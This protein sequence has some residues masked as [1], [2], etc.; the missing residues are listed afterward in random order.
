MR[1]VSRSSKEAAWKRV[2]NFYEQRTASQ[3]VLAPQT[4]GVMADAAQGR[5][6]KGAM[7]G[8]GAGIVAAIGMTALQFLFDAVNG[9][10]SS[11]AVRELSERGGRHDI[12]Q[13]KERAR[14][15]GLG[16]RD[17]T[18]RAADVLA[19]RLS[20][21]A[22]PRRHR[23]KAGLAVHYIFAA[24]TGALQGIVAERYVSRTRGGLFFGAMLWLFAEEIALPLCGLTRMPHKYRLQEHS[25]GFVAHLLFG[26]TTFGVHRW[27]RRQF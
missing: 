26:W 24:S 25:N 16:Q 3:G 7:A 13:L 15:T 19:R 27:I 2:T 18:V 12:A 6:L 20:G 22:L 4:R 11:V 9:R 8:A 1:H 21:H 5:I 23:H 10:V 17:A 14:I